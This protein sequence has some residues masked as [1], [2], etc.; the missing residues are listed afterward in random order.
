LALQPATARAIAAKIR[1]R[2]ETGG[3]RMSFRRR[4]GKG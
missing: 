2:L 3:R 1:R 4:S